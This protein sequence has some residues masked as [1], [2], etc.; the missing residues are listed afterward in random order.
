MIYYVCRDDNAPSGGRRVL[1]RHVDILNEAGIPASILHMNPNFRLTWFQNETAVANFQDAVITP[2]DYLV[3]PETFGPDIMRFASIMRFV[4]QA[5]IVI[6]N[7]NAH[8]THSGYRGDEQKTAY[9]LGNLKGVMVVSDH[10]KELLEY[11]FPFLTVDRVIVGIDTDLFTYSPDK[12]KLICYMPRRGAQDIA[13]VIHT[14][15]WRGALEG[16]QVVAI[17][18]LSHEGVAAVMKRAAIFLASGS[19]EGCPMPPLE[20][21]AC[22]CVVIG[23]DGYGGRDYWK[24]LR[25]RYVNPGDILE[26]SLQAEGAI[27]YFNERGHNATI[28]PG[29]SGDISFKYSPTAERDSVLAFWGKRGEA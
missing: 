27:E 19:Q 7:Q 9:H 5:N 23:Y 6:F 14:L 29:I 22:G 1:Y 2:D 20:A 24:Y 17:D 28:R 21:A 4:G 16:W 12:E 18:G 13:Q 8:Y 10:N 25:P 15:K 26:F 11:T 3:F